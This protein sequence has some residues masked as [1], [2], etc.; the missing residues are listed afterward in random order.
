MAEILEELLRGLTEWLAVILLTLLVLLACGLVVSIIRQRSIGRGAR[1]TAE[2]VAEV[3]QDLLRISPTRVWA[4]ATHSYKEAIRR[5]VLLVL[6]IFGLVLLF[7]GWFLEVPPHYQVK[8]YISFVYRT[9]GVLLFMVGLMLACTGLPADIQRKTIHTVVTKPVLRLEIV[10][11]RFLGVSLLSTGILALMAAVSYVYL[12]RTTGLWG[13]SGMLQ[14]LERHVQELRQRG[15][16]READHAQENLE[17]I[18]NSLK[19][20]VPLYGT[21]T[22]IDERGQESGKGVD[23]G[24]ESTRRSFVPG[25][26]AAYARW[27]FRGIPEERFLQRQE[28]PVELEFEVFRTIVG[29]D[30]EIERGVKAE[31]TFRNPHTGYYVRDYPFYVRERRQRQ[32]LRD[33]PHTPEN[34]LQRLL[35]DC[36]GELI[37][38]ARCLSPSQ[39]IGMAQDD[40]YLLVED[41][42]GFGLNYFKGMIG[43]W[44]QVELVI[45]LAV[46]FS[47]FLSTPVALLATLTALICGLFMDFVAGV[48]FGQLAGGGLLESF[49]RIVTHENLVREL[50]D[51]FW[52]RVAKALD[53]HFFNR[54]LQGVLLVVPDLTQFS[55]WDRVA[56]G[57]YIPESN[58]LLSLVKSLGYLVPF[59]LV[60][61]VMLRSREIAR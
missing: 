51:T 56:N 39:Y 48:A 11:G 2:L 20:R 1:A 30:E 33:L 47:T 46:A 38:E 35:K 10:L 29:N 53:A 42:A 52:I 19:A 31:L 5:R 55:I 3:V 21:L 60:G 24:F 40:L 28:L 7:A 13:T 34:D 54:A 37:L 18:V 4:L 32:V 9:I 17:Q 15:Q 6:V 26:T 12:L 44:L 43:V 16:T 41:D 59:L 14:A 58:V 49:I 27:Y 61:H 25:A 8:A 22:F 57:F 36:Q 45:A 50:P 23:V